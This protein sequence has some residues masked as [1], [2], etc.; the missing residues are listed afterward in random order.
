M[1]QGASSF[2]SDSDRLSTAA[3]AAAYAAMFAAPWFTAG[4]DATLMIRPQRFAFMRREAARAQ[5]NALVALSF[6]ILSHRGGSVSSS[7]A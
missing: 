7:A 3:F 2:A 1:P 4:P 5:R 6:I